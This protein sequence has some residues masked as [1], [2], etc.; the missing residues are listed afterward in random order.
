MPDHYYYVEASDRQSLTTSNDNVNEPTI[1]PHILYE[2]TRQ[3][4]RPNQQLRTEISALQL[5]NDEDNDYARWS[6][7]FEVKEDFPLQ[8][9]IGNYT[10]NLT[11][12][13]YEMHSQSSGASTKLGT[14]AQTSPSATL[15]WR[16][17]VAVTGFGRA[18]IVQPRAQVTYVGGNDRTADIPNLSLIH[19]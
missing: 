1:L 14:V 18:A 7:V 13:Y 10:A 11:A 5:D 3:G 19:I 8:M 15:G 2:K 12:N 17:P 9:G 6:G 4:W 16:L